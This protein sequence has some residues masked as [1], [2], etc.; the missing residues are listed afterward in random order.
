[1]NKKKKIIYI[2][3]FIDK[4]LI[5]EWMAAHFANSKVFEIKYLLMNPGETDLSKFME[6]NKIPFKNIRYEGKKD[7]FSALLKIIRYLKKEKPDIV[8]TNLIDASL[9][10]QIAAY[11]SGIKRRIH[12]RHYSSLH[13][14]YHARGLWYDKIINRLCTEIIVATQMVK[15]LLTEKENV[16]PSKIKII[17]YGLKLDQF[18]NVEPQRVN[19]LKKKYNIENAFPVVGAISRFLHWKGVQ[20]LIPAFRILLND[21]PKA[22]LVLANARGNYKD[23]LEKLLSEIPGK[24]YTL[25]QYENDSPALYRMFHFFVHVPVSYHAEAFGQIY[26]E[27]LASGVPG[28][29][30]I[31]GIANDFI[32]NEKNAIIVPY[33][34]SEAIYEAIRKLIGDEALKAKITAQGRKDVLELFQFE[35][36]IKKTEMLFNED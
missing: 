2:I 11:I 23:E 5:Y 25:I 31:S 26:I 9:V 12:S 10:G 7:F 34:N 36:M 19:D 14:V 17:N 28:I 4:A 30:T 35:T 3:S 16:P 15:N 21:F 6:S 13:H 18:I 20:Y 24:N 29:F 33:M 22:H 27:S 32:K 8:N 1:M